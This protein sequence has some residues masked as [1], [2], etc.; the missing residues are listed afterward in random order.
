MRFIPL[1]ILF[2]SHV[3]SSAQ[4]TIGTL[5]AIETNNDGIICYGED[6]SFNILGASNMPSDLGIPAVNYNPGV[7]I[8]IF[9]APP[10]YSNNEVA[11]DPA[12]MGIVE[13]QPY[14]VLLAPFVFD[15]N[16]LIGTIPPPLNN[17]NSP[18]TLY[19]QAITLYDVD[20]NLPYITIPGNTLDAAQSNTIQLTIQPEILVSSNQNCLNNWI[21]ITASQ[22]GM[23]NISF[24]INN[25]FP[26]S[27]TFPVSIVNQ[28]TDNIT[29][30]TGNNIPYGLDI[31]NPDGCF[32]SINNIYIG[33]T[34]SSIDP[35]GTLCEGDSPINLNAQPPGGTWTGNINILNNGVFDPA[36]VDINSS[37]NYTVGYSPLVPAGG[38]ALSSSITITVLPDANSQFSA[39]IEICINENPVT[40]L[41]I[42]S[43]G[44]WSGP[45]NCVNNQG[46]FDPSLSGSGTQT[47]IYAIGGTCPSYS[48]QDIIVNS[49]PVIQ[50]DASA[51]EGCLPLSVD[52]TNTTAG[53][54]TDVVWT[55]NG[56]Q[57]AAGSNSFTYIFENSFC[58]NVGLSLTSEQGCINS[59]D[60]LNLICPYP[61]PIVDFEYNP[62]KPTLA[63]F[64]ITFYETLGNTANHIWEFGDGQTSFEWSPSHY[65]D[66]V[67]PSEFE[68]CLTGYDIAGCETKVCKYLQIASAFEMFC[69]TAFTPGN[70]GL[71]DGFRPVLVSKREVF[72][73]NMR[74]Y[75]RN[76]EKIF[77]T[78]D[79]KQAWY[80]NSFK[81]DI[82][83]PDGAYTWVIEIVLEGLS[84]RQTFKGSVLI[85]R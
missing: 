6:F 15:F 56:L 46:L 80:G 11:S 1:F 12:L 34:V 42:E 79:Y 54:N 2:F 41:P 69:P 37:T 10:S 83:V 55:I 65:F 40:L 84:E 51:T 48:T 66:V 63:D 29:N 82:Y 45:N 59:M 17:L 58:H 49:L 20:I 4:A 52:F 9:A 78:D 36:G 18:I 50:F 61:D 72:K 68:V 44:V 73:Y 67:V 21:E 8:A 31:I 76:G 70:D 43:G 16:T 71:N 23:G 81:G 26:I 77:E 74:I 30:L 35:V 24:D 64:E 19:F 28:S 75:N 38:C 33:S 47:I 14:N 22:S 62:T 32:T 27:A 13:S 25:T 3:L 39:P 53:N 5:T 85:V 60:S 7:G 57:A